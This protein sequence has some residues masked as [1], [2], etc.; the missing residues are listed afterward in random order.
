MR[1]RELALVLH[2]GS[3]VQRTEGL[4]DRTAHH[5]L[6]L[7]VHRLVLADELVSF[8]LRVRAVVGAGHVVRERGHLVE[9]HLRPLVERMVVALRALHAGAEEDADGV[10][11]VVQRHATIAHVVADRAGFE[12]VALRRDQ[13]AGKLVIRLVLAQRVADIV[14]ISL[15]REVAAD[16]CALRAQDVG[17]VVEEVVHVAVAGQ[18]LVDELRA[19]VRRLG[20]QKRGG[21][22]KSRDASGDIKIDTAQERRIIGRLVG[23]H[24]R[25]FPFLGENGVDLARCRGGVGSGVDHAAGEQRTGRNQGREFHA[26]LNSLRPPSSHPVVVNASAFLAWHSRARQTLCKPR[27]TCEAPRHSQD[28]S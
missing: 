16:A 25:G 27:F 10:G 7:L 14:Q 1:Q 18:E 24:L 13:L 15:R 8:R 9:V 17:P 6:R 4:G 2:D 11:D 5:V 20:V 28:E 22:L 12:A 26:S 3:T 23:L 19:F 21:L